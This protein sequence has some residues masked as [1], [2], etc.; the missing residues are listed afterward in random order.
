MSKSIWPTVAILLLILVAGAYIAYSYSQPQLPPDTANEEGNQEDTKSAD[1]TVSIQQCP[2]SKV[3]NNMPQIVEEG[4]PADSSSYY[5]WKGNRYEISQFDAEW[6]ARN[7]D[8]KTE[9]V[10]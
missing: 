4:E 9:Q 5:I 3:V 2:D 10:Y 1:N 7:C 6:V 8:V